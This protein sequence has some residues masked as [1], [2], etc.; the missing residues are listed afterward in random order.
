MSH[1]TP[2]VLLLTG[3]PG[4]GKTTIIRT[5]AERLRP[6]PLSGFYTEEIRSH[7]QR[8]GFRLVTLA[9]ESAVIAHTE[10]PKT[11]R[12]GRY[13][14]DVAAID[15][16]S[17]QVLSPAAGAIHLVDE[18]GKMECLSTRFVAAMRRLL[19]SQA[20]VV[21][22]VGQRGG[23]FIVEVKRRPDTVLWEVTRANREELPAHALDWI[24]RHEP[25]SS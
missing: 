12:V 15:T 4:V 7:S 22:T 6:R 13:G 11:Q 3:V 19:D 17:D 9:G 8:Q 23:G 24:V 16:V 10:F 20:V 18:I 14:V 5:L 2:H 1:V 21:A 25:S